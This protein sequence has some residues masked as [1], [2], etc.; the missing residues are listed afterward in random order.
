MPFAILFFFISF[1]LSLLHP[2]S[3]ISM[4]SE[5]DYSDDDNDYSDPMD[6]DDDDL[7][8]QYEGKYYNLPGACY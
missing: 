4:S 3:A 2:L 8:G 1:S 6:M 7:G 5:Y